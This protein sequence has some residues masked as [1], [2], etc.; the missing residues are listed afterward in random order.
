[1]DGIIAVIKHAGK[2]TSAGQTVG[3][4]TCDVKDKATLKWFRT[5]DCQ[6][7]SFIPAIEITKYGYIVLY[8][9]SIN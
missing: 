4:Y 8:K 2:L 9:K 1:M 5:N 7:P 3:H 6:M